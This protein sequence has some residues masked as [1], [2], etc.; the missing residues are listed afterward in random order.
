MGAVHATCVYLLGQCECTVAS[1]VTPLVLP[2]MCWHQ[3][4]FAM[5]TPTLNLFRAVACHVTRPVTSQFKCSSG[6]GELLSG[7]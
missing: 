6:A 2:G 1:R 3:Q 5:V 7:V 4:S